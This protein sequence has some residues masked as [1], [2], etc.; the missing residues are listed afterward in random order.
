MAYKNRHRHKVWIFLLFFGIGIIDVGFNR[1]S[2]LTDKEM[3]GYVMGEGVVKDVKTKSDG[4]SF[5]IGMTRMADSAGNVKDCRNLDIM[6]QTD[7][8][9]AKK[10]ELLVFPIKLEVITDNPN[11]RSSGYA[12]K[13]RRQGIIYRSNA[14]AERIHTKSCEK[15]LSGKSEDCRDYLIAKIENSSLSRPSVD[16]LTA[17]M[18]GD[19]SFLSDELRNSFSNAGVAHVLALSGMHVAIIMGIILLILFPLCFIG[20]HGARLWLAVALLW[21]YA[22]VSGL[23][24]STVRACIMTTF[25]VIALTLQRKN[26]S[27]N[28]LLASAFTILVFDPY[29][30]Y[31][32]G[33][34]LS[35]LC[36]ACILMFAGQLNPVNRHFHPRL[37]S[38]TSSVLV[39]L[40]ATVGTWVLVSYYF[41]KIPLLFL[42]AN[43]LILPLLPV[44]MSV[45]FIYLI[46]LL[47]GIDAVFIASIL[48]FG[49]DIFVWI[50]D[51]ISSFG[52]AVIDYQVQLPVVIIWLI[53][54]MT[55]GYAINKRKRKVAIFSGAFFLVSAMVMIPL[56]TERKPDGMIIQKNYNQISLAV[57][58]SDNEVVRY[59]PRNTVSRWMHKGSEILAMDCL[60]EL[61]S[62]S[63]YIG[64]G[65]K[66]KKRYLILG[67]G[68][69]NIKLSDIS[70]VESFDKIILHSSLRRKM[71]NKIKQEANEIG[72]RNVHSLREDGPL[73]LEF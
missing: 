71:E 58:D 21:G 64:A 57:Y 62:I 32:V 52:N 67:S 31:D 10:G 13:M 61:D 20:L 9:S 11:Y 66:S 5:I 70:G 41:K 45:A 65:K 50:T 36:V 17:M 28:A 42:P 53:G 23:A 63:R 12:E 35:F 73:E 24:P 30:I 40:V 7:G 29:A 38:A 59:M 3:S 16:F 72:L 34:Q 48:D 69:R 51:R 43:L 25:V 22:F 60:S 6:L 49:Y 56:C 54:V 46:L 39:S 55:V 47:F 4:D 68:A 15:N 18:F 19:R 27:G 44:F 2:E 26:A 33:L 14:T 8:Y 37:Y 1:P